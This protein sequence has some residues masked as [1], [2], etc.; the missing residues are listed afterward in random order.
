MAQSYALL[1]KKGKVNSEK[2]AAAQK[3][4]EYL[5]L[6]DNSNYGK[7][8]MARR[9]IAPAQIALGMYDEALA[10]YDELE[11]RMAGD[12]LNDDYAVILRSRAIA[13]RAMGHMAEALD[14][15]TRYANL[16]KAVSDSLYRSKAHDYAARYHAYE[17]QLQ[18]QEKEAEAQRSRIINIALAIGLLI[19]LVAAIYIYCQK[20]I[21]NKKNRALVKL[22]NSSSTKKVATSTADSQDSL[23]NE[24]DTAI[25]NEHLYTIVTLQRQDIC[26]RFGISRHALNDLLAAHANGLSFPQYINNIRTQEALRLLRDEPGKTVSAIATEVG[27]TPANLREQF[28]QA[29]GMTPSVKRSPSL[30]PW[31]L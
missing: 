12:T 2:L 10:T 15:Q 21:V 1:S 26:E 16:S 24:I 30:A 8:F 7:T 9:M 11:R 4:H 13:A 17:Q 3:A 20:R 25:R 27:F 5:E 28:K 22:I 23:F 19:V 18:I 29:Y 31:R 6:F 14:F